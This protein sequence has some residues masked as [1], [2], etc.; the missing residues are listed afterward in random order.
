MEQ[1][2]WSLRSQV[3][4]TGVGSPEKS[5]NNCFGNV[6]GV[7]Q[8]IQAASVRHAHYDVLDTAMRRLVHGGG[9]QWHEAFAS[10]QAELL[11]PWIRRP[12]MMFER[13]R[14]DE[15][16]QHAQGI[17]DGRRRRSTD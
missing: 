10:L 15:Q 17:V 7:S 11:V 8:H 5:E 2:K 16:F 4:G 6:E 3:A 14:Q 13:F 9:E 1:P 12:L